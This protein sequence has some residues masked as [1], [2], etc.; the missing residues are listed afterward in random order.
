MA[1]TERG[2]RIVPSSTVEEKLAQADLS[3]REASAI[4]GFYNDAQIKALKVALLSVA[5]FVLISFW[6]TFA[7]PERPPDGDRRLGGD[8]R[9]RG[10]LAR[11]LLASGLIQLEL[12]KTYRLRRYFNA[13]I[14]AQEL[15]GCFQ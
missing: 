4:V 8:S 2:I 3:P 14:L 5:G 6:V 10:A 7:L 12:T 9:S 15:K 11:G 13:L 1:A